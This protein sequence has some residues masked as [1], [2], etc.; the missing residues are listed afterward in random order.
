VGI[1]ALGFKIANSI[2]VFIVRSVQLALAPMNYKMMNQPDNI[3]FYSKIMTYFTY[4]I[5]FFV[6][7]FSIY[8]FE[9]ISLLARNKDYW[10]AYKI[11][12]LISF[13]IL[14]DMLRATSTIGLNIKKETKL[15]AVI[16]T[17]MS[18]FNLALNLALIPY[19]SYIGAALATLITNIVFFF[20][21][22]YQA[23]KYYYIPYEY[24]KIAKMILVGAGIVC[25]SF[26][27]GELELF[28]R[29]IVKLCLLL[30]FPVILYYWNFYE[31]VELTKL[32]QAWEKWRNPSKWKE[33]LQKIKIPR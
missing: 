26:I 27:L 32:R 33:N 30:I 31:E 19:Y 12:P 11:I 21:I 2:K 23:Q 8:S 15:I 5:M 16:F 28:T 25:I 17:I 24:K 4:G 20:L 9:M 29:L 22:I 14:F 10:D 18:I 1:Y 6:I 7:A 13:A 3:R